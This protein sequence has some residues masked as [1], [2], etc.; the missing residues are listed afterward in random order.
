MR[1][2]ERPG[3]AAV[4]VVINNDDKAAEIEFDVCAIAV[5]SER[6][7][8]KGSTRRQ[9]RCSGYRTAS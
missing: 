7:F 6:L 8:A 9:P 2:R 5:V 1:M 4:V 3:H